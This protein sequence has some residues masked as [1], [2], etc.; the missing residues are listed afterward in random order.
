MNNRMASSGPVYLNA[1]IN[2]SGYDEETQPIVWI[3]TEKH[4]S[5]SGAIVPKAKDYYASV[6]RLVFDMDVPVFIAEMQLPSVDGVST[7][8][9]VTIESDIAGAVHQ[10][11]AY[12]KLPYLP[13][14]AV[15]HQTQPKD[16]YS[17][18][19]NYSELAHQ[20]NVMLAEAYAALIAAGSTVNPAE[21]PFYTFEADGSL[22]LNVYPFSLYESTQPLPANNV[23]IYFNAPSYPL[24]K[25]WD[26]YPV[27]PVGGTPA[28][29]GKDFWLQMFNTGK[30]YLP[31]PTVY[32]TGLTPVAPT[33]SS[34]TIA[35]AFLAAFPGIVSIIVLSDLPSAGE[36]VQSSKDNEQAKILTD[37]KPDLSNAGGATTQFYNAN[38]GDCRWI[39]LTG[40]APISQL[41]VRIE[42]IDYLG[43]RH[44]L[45]LYSKSEQASM[46]I[47]FAPKDMVETSE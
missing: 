9:S 6:F 43:V 2:N 33:T 28:T 21:V 29:D 12:L 36:Y 13:A 5:R 1:E 42:A 19:W 23:R 47:C 10:G 32:S 4:I 27:T 20:L 31:A 18:F 16:F 8:Y 25:G 14:D 38:F 35:P 45:K 3:N 7:I 37:F 17:A 26:W 24:I 22:S 44:T 34:L 41:T 39:K 46:K 15:L 40:D 11:R 30:N